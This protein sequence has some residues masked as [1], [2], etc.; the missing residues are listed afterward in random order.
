MTSAYLALGMLNGLI[1]TSDCWRPNGV[2]SFQ[3][4]DETSVVEVEEV[5]EEVWHA[6]PKAWSQMAVEMQSRI[7]PTSRLASIKDLVVIAGRS[8]LLKLL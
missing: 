5:V 7:A 4:E 2:E 3:E 8:S 1:V 6:W